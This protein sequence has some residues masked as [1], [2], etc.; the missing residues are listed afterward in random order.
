VEVWR[1][2]SKEDQLSVISGLGHIGG[3]VVSDYI[4]R[5]ARHGETFFCVMLCMP[6]VYEKWK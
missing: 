5:D 1:Q 6:D 2:G 4:I 3:F